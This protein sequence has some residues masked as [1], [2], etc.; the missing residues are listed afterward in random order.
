MRTLIKELP[1]SK[2]FGKQPKVTSGVDYKSWT[3]NQIVFSLLKTGF[4]TV[5]NSFYIVRE[6]FC[7]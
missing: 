6:I 5:P 7:N 1:K 4:G 2:Y 3:K